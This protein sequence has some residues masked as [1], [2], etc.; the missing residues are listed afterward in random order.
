LLKKVS[1]TSPIDSVD[2][3]PPGIVDM[4]FEYGKGRRG[5]A[6]VARVLLITLALFSAVSIASAQTD[7][8]ETAAPDLNL[9][10]PKR[11]NSKELLDMPSLTLEH[12]NH[13]ADIADS[14]NLPSM[15]DASEGGD[16]EDEE[17]SKEHYDELAAKYKAQRETVK[18]FSGRDD[19]SAT[20]ACKADI[21][22]LC[23][24]DLMVDG[25]KP[26]TGDEGTTPRRALLEEDGGQDGGHR[27]GCFFQ[28]GYRGG[29]G[30]KDRRPRG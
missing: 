12:L 17:H 29:Q 11:S 3:A 18:S 16:G 24:A 13:A 1:T 14:G 6:R 19:I 15:G 23:A 4:G 27:F 25:F 30:Q 5:I 21:E 7:D 10:E 9:L 2:I 26:V 28:G 20:G 8:E 22:K